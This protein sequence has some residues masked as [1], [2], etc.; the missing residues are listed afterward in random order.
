MRRPHKVQKIGLAMVLAG[1][2]LGGSAASASTTQVVQIGDNCGG[3]MHCYS[4]PAASA[5]SGD[6]VTWQSTSIEKHTVTACTP[7]QCAGNGPGTG[8]D[9]HLAS[10]TILPGGSYSFT[11]QGKGTYLYY[12]KIH[13]Y[14]VMHGTVTVS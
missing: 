11:F 8:T 14:G 10:R 3:S 13:G 5:L 12:C 9:K 6:T 2:V 4:P 7:N 1:A